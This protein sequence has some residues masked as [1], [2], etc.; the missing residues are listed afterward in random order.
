MNKKL[1]YKVIISIVATSLFLGLLYNTF[2]SDGIPLLR[3]KMT[4]KFV[5]IGNTDSSS[6]DLKGLQLEQVIEIYQQGNA[7][8]IDSRDRPLLLE[9]VP[10]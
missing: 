1:S 9:P 5:S 3:K 7:I 6:T 10:G 8:F 2:S 4:V